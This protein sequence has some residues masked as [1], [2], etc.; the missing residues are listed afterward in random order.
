MAS[1]WVRGGKSVSLVP[2][3]ESFRAED[4]GLAGA[5][6]ESLQAGLAEA[7]GGRRPEHSTQREGEGNCGFT[8]LGPHPLCAVAPTRSQ[9][10][11]ALP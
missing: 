5:A 1:G 4:F 9:Q 10:L 11:A 2:V 8:G 3:R 7:T 6:P